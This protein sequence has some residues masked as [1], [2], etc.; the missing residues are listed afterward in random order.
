VL[1]GL[2]VDCWA[3]D[4]P[5]RPTAA[6]V[7]SRLSAEN[8]DQLT[9]KPELI[10]PCAALNQ[11]QEPE[12]P[13]S[14]SQSTLCSTRNNTVRSFFFTDFHI[15]SPNPCSV[16]YFHVPLLAQISQSSFWRAQPA[17]SSSQTTVVS[18]TIPNDPKVTIMKNCRVVI[19]YAFTSI[20]GVIW[21]YS[22]C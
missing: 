1:W 9:A 7:C 12:I 13:T 5:R 8:V 6:I 21:T 19:L 20:T 15:P 14:G 11:A 3:H 22:P 18:R 16:R 4:P 10:S 2:I 17:S